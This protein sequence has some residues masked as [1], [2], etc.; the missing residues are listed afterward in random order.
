MWRRPRFPPYVADSALALLLA[1]PTVGGLV[2]DAEHVTQPWWLVGPLAALTALPLAVRRYRPLAVFAITLGALVALNF[3]GVDTFAPGIAVAVYTL[4]A[5]CDR[6][7]ALRAGVLGLALY[8]PA[9]L[10]ASGGSVVPS[11]VFLTAAWILG[12]NLRTRRAYLHEL[13]EKAERLEREREENERRAAADEQARIARELHDVIA[14]NVSVMVVQAAGGREVFETHPD[15]A[16]EALASIEA[17]GREALTEL[18][19]LLGVAR[20]HEDGSTSLAPQPGLERLGTL[21]E[22]VRAAGLTVDVQVEGEQRDLP[23]GVDL[24]AYRVIQEALTN[25]LRHAFAQRAWVVVHYGERELIVEVLDDGAGPP[26]AGGQDGRGLV[27]MQERVGLFGGE[28]RT[29]A[30]PEGGFRVWARF[31]LGA[32][33]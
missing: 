32:E 2:A 15:R 18:R 22:Q 27:G 14:H 13:E 3:S 21:V 9:S 4:A 24:S 26:R 7:T 12:D 29:G 6:R 8:V 31:P 28:V 33:G 23:T 1:V 5:H 17:T 20:A 11:V 16:R 30:R 19:R 25:T 10:Y